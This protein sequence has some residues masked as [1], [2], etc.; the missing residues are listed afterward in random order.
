MRLTIF[1]FD[2]PYPPHRG[3]RAD[4]WRRIV[5]LHALGC[6]IQLVCWINRENKAPTADE[7]EHI[8]SKVT[9]LNVYK[10]RQGKA[11]FVA[12]LAR[13]CKAP[14]H[15]SARRLSDQECKV[16]QVETQAFDPDVVWIE[17]PY[18]AEVGL[19]IASSLNK[20]VFYRSHNIEHLYMQRQ[21]D[22]AKSWRQKL[23]W[24]L[25]CFGLK[26]F[27]LNVMQRAEHVFDISTDD[28][29]L[30]NSLGVAN[31]S[32]LP[33]LPEAAIRPSRAAGSAPSRDVVFV[34]NLTTPNNIQGVE[35]LV[36]EV[37]PLVW[38]QL[39][40]VRLTI[41]GSTPAERTRRLVACDRRVEL[42]EDVPDAVEV[43]ASAQVLVNPVQ[44]GS[45]VMVKVLDML[46][47]DAPVVSSPQGAC[48]LPLVV[49]QQLRI[50]DGSADFAAAVVD[51]LQKPGINAA[52][53]ES[54][55]EYFSLQ[56]IRQLAARLR[57]WVFA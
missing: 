52:A 53:R 39:P 55:R 36:Q 47:T 45:G 8:H 42:L 29:A 33:P 38:Q 7:L 14:S 48:G 17:G 3:G 30:W 12:R 43:M 9:L 20:P 11:E 16:L 35:F 28:M 57:V 2:I 21:A 24:R 19:R 34:G 25:A 50:A 56:S 32:C 5:A 40:D 49:R 27:E 4:V 13:I 31:I 41:A 37:M 6:Q 22:A 26:R 51:C 44:T 46:M 54:A 23:S 18:P 10:L 1:A 15:V